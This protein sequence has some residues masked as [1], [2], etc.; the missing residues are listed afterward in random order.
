[1]KKIV[2][3]F[4]KILLINHVY[5]L[6][7][8]CKTLRAS[9]WVWKLRRAK[10]GTWPLTNAVVVVVYQ[11]S[12][13]NVMVSLGILKLF[14]K[15]RLNV[16]CLENQWSLC[17]VLWIRIRTFFSPPP[18]PDRAKHQPKKIFTKLYFS[19][20]FTNFYLNSLS[21][22]FILPLLQNL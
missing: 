10:P 7:Y 3:L 15:A 19:F 5:C 13:S 4:I 17:S 14:C 22:E 11:C 6:T 12:I 2:E 1:M 16:R 8:N 18:D 21:V 9:S 20:S